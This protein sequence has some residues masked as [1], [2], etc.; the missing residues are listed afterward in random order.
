MLTWVVIF[1]L[2]AIAAAVLGFG[3]AAAAFAAIAKLVFY[4]AIVLLVVS[5]AGHLM[6]R[7]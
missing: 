5:L 2:V 4:V 1:F 6:R 3:M 7:V